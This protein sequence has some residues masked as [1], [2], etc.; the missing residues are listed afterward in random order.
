MHST[1][2]MFPTCQLLLLLLFK[3][4]IIKHTE[5]R[6][7][8]LMTPGTTL[9]QPPENWGDWLSIIHSPDKHTGYLGCAGPHPQTWQQF[10]DQKTASSRS[11][12][13]CANSHTQT[14][15]AAT[16]EVG[17]HKGAGDTGLSL[18]PRAAGAGTG[19]CTDTHLWNCHRKC[20][21]HPRCHCLQRGLCS[22]CPHTS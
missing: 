2:K 14:S 20:Q 18:E 9:P 10:A 6:G 11:S 13:W 7:R 21:H 5:R 22:C 12:V 4:F 16:Q 17:E 8:S 1:Q 15:T 3:V 19:V